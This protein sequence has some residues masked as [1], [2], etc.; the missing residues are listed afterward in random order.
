M[1]FPFSVSC[2]SIEHVY[3]TGGFDESKNT[4]AQV[5]QVDP[6]NGRVIHLHPMT[7]R[8]HSHSAAIIDNHIFVFGGFDNVSGKFLSSC[9]KYN[10]ITDR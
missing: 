10:P 4:T 9:E 7:K 6:S 8:R 2:A 1:V 3:I 5:D